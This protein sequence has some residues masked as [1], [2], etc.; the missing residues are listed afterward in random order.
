MTELE[1]VD[2][3]RWQAARKIVWERDGRRCVYCDRRVRLTQA[4]IHHLL[5]KLEIKSLAMKIALSMSTWEMRE[6]VFQ[7][8]FDVLFYYP[9][10]L[11]TL[12]QDCHEGLEKELQRD[13][14]K[15]ATLNHQLKELMS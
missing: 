12:C 1:L 6:K 13:M 4:S 15:I 2:E 5:S 3:E 10:N 7:R 8:A 11:I 9:R 14:Y